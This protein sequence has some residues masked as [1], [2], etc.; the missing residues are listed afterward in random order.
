MNNGNPNQG[1]IDSL[2]ESGKIKPPMIVDVGHHTVKYA[3]AN[4][5]NVTVSKYESGIQPLQAGRVEDWEDMEEMLKSFVPQ[6]Y[7]T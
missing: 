1:L 2:S 7:F 3:H 5:K 4:Q 6:P